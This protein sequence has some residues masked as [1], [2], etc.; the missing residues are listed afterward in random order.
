LRDSVAVEY[1]R[2]VDPAAIYGGKE[3]EEILRSRVETI[4]RRDHR[5]IFYTVAAK[6]GVL[7]CMLVLCT[8]IGLAA[9]ILRP[10]SL[11]TELAFWL[12]MAVAAIPG[13]VAIPVP[14][15]VLGMITLA[16]LY[17]YYSLI[18]YIERPSA[19]PNK[20]TRIPGTHP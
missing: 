14:P 19:T 17:W 3:Y 16:L 5:F 12:A 13:I 18:F 2:A 11:G 8:N 6:A 7:A 15:Y 9:A 10:K 1:V 20:T 4:I